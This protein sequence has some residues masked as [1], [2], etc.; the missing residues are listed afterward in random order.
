MA[1]SGTLFFTFYRSKYAKKRVKNHWCFL[2]KS[3]SS[4]GFRRSYFDHFRVVNRVKTGVSR[5]PV[6]E[7]SSNL[8]VPPFWVIS[9]YPYSLMAQRV[10]HFL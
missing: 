2:S 5:Y 6:L 3:G 10:C 9:G 4:F 8:V 7:K 1:K